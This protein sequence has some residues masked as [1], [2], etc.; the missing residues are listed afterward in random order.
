MGEEIMAPNCVQVAL[1]ATSVIINCGVPGSESNEDFSEHSHCG[2]FLELHRENG[3]PYHPDENF[4]INERRITTSLV[5]GY[6]T[7]TINLTYGVGVT[8]KILCNY[9]ESSMRVGSMVYIKETAPECCCPPAYNN[10]EKTGTIFCPSNMY[11][12]T[13]GPFATRLRTLDHLKQNDVDVNA[14]PYCPT[15]D[16]GTDSLQCCNKTKAWG[17][18]RNFNEQCPDISGNNDT[19]LFTSPYMNGDYNGRCFYFEGC[20]AHPLRAGEYAEGASTST[21]DYVASDGGR[22]CKAHPRCGEG[23]A[24]EPSEKDNY[25]SFKG[26]VGKITCIPNP[27]LSCVDMSLPKFDEDSVYYLVTFNDGR[28]EYPFRDVDLIMHQPRHN[29]QL[30]WV[31]RTR[32]NFIIQKKKALRVTEPTCTFDSVNDRYFPYTIVR[33]DGSYVDTL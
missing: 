4:I 10:E 31:Q 2:T 24:C 7:T 30:W 11:E 1:T 22:P 3:S 16:E 32:F 9:E 27:K 28:T 12:N 14:Y 33:E 5:S 19:G 6:T 25:F 29:Y 15:M 18:Y 21:I 23:G 26:L 8:D 20:A 13:R 17:A